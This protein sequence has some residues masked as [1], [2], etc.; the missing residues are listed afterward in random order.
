METSRGSHH[1]K[2]QDIN[3]LMAAVFWDMHGVLLLHITP[4]NEKVIS[5][6]YQATQLF[7]AIGL[8][9]QTRGR[10]CCM[11]IPERIQLMK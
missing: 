3:K 1:Q 5:A 11:T 4:P 6:V 7:N 9:C 10:C 8:R 2:I